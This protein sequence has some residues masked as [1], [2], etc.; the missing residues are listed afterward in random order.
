MVERTSVKVKIRYVK[1]FLIKSNAKEIGR[2]TQWNSS[3]SIKLS[4]ERREIAL[5]NSNC[6]SG[7]DGSNPRFT[8][9]QGNNNF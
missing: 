4:E 6:F 2:A 7:A 9:A 1:A 5:G 3:L 8:V